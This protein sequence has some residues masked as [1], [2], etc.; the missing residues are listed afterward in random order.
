VDEQPLYYIVIVLGL[1]LRTHM[2]A[3]IKLSHKT[4]PVTIVDLSNQKTAEVIKRLDEAQKE[5][6]TNAPK[7]V[8]LA[9]DV[10][11]IEITNDAISAVITFAKKNTPYVKAS[12]TVA[13]NKMLNLIAFNVANSAGRKIN[14]FGTRDEAMDWLVKQP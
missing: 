12:A 13:D 7:S 3:T 11:N 6:S 9:T 5:I 14:S 4:K 1:E 2:T 8:L 10:T